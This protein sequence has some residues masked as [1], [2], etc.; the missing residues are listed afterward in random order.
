MTYKH[1]TRYL[2]AH[3]LSYAAYLKTPHWRELRQR[4][5]AAEKECYICG[6]TSGLEVHH[7]SYKRV[8][9]ERLSDLCLLCGACHE[10]VHKLANTPYKHM[11][12]GT[13]LWIAARKLRHMR[14]NPNDRSVVP[15]AYSP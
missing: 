4:K 8:G 10:A 15:K 9:A 14:N 12:A 13:R 11:N 7:M 1:L 5:V 2:Q 3:N 6:A